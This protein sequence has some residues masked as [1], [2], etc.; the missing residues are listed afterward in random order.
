MLATVFYGKCPHQGYLDHWL[1]F[2]VNRPSPVSVEW[3]GYHGG[4]P[5][6]LEGP[7]K[8]GRAD[9]V[10]ADRGYADKEPQPY[11]DQKSGLVP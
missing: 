7:L 11:L 3:C 2:S 4:G 8:K 1:L 6:V 5:V 10:D 9:S